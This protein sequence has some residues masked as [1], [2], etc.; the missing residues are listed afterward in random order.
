M[1]EG[2]KKILNERKKNCLTLSS[3]LEGVRK[4]PENKKKNI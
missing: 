1:N 4:L 3:E 2:N